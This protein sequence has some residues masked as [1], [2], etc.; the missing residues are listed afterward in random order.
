MSKGKNMIIHL[1]VASMKKNE[2]QFPL[3]KNEPIF[4]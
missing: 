3:Y 2:I 1:I 4:P